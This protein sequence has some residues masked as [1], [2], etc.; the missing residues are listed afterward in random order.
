MK[1][2]LTVKTAALVCMALLVSVT[3][4]YLVAAD[5]VDSP[6]VIGTGSDI[7]DVYA[8]QS[9]S[10]SA[11]LVFAVNVQ[12]FLA[13]GSATNNASFDEEV[14]IEINIDNTGDNIEDLVIQAT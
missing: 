8:F 10:N 1:Q 14:M 7:T 13:P 9:P 12:G 5:H 3:S 4:V 2:K 11:N 6:A